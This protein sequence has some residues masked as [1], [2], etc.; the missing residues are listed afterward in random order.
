MKRVRTAT[1]TSTILPIISAL[2]SDHIS[3]S[4]DLPASPKVRLFLP[5]SFLSI[6][7]IPNIY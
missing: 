1:Q 5:F 6:N 7:H 3:P 2:I 4:H